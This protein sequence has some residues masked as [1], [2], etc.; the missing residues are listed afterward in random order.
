MHTNSYRGFIGIDPGATCGIAWALYDQQTNRWQ[1]K[2][3]SCDP[4]A[5]LF[6]LRH[7][8]QELQEI[9]R[10]SVLVSGEKFV[11][12][13]KAGTKGANADLT[14]EYLQKALSLAADLGAT[15]VTHTASEAKHWATD[16]RL[17]AVNFPLASKL[18]D[19]RDAGRHLIFS[20][21][22]SGRAQD[23]LR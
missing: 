8:V 9:T 1:I 21:V 17:Q 22:H 6:I 12:G 4:Q 2:A 13:N 16:R 20:A 23:P 10:A 5:M 14:R 15:T 18:K 19:S 11:T 3:A 7:A